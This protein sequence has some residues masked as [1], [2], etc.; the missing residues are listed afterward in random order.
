MKDIDKTKQR[1]DERYRCYLKG[2]PVYEIDNITPND[3]NDPLNA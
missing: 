3:K 1:I 2:C